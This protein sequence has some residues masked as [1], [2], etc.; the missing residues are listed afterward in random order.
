MWQEKYE[1]LR[2]KIDSLEALDGWYVSE[3]NINNYFGFNLSIYDSIFKLQ[4]IGYKNW[5]E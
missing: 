5:N 4:I 2:R 1:I 3:I